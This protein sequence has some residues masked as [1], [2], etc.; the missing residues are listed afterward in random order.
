MVM[1]VVVPVSVIVIVVPVSVD[2]ISHVVVVGNNSVDL[3]SSNVDSSVLDL[4]IGLMLNLLECFLMMVM[5]LLVMVMSS[6]LTNNHMV[7]LVVAVSAAVMVASS[8][9]FVSV[10]SMPVSIVVMV[11]VATDSVDC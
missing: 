10:H 1:G 2:N 8:D 3:R 11:I 7:T 4:D 6:F 9:D 5:S